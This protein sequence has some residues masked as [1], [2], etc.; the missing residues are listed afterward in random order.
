MVAAMPP[1]AWR[2][3]FR[4]REGAVYACLLLRRS[5]LAALLRRQG[6][7]LRLSRLHPHSPRLTQR[8]VRPLNNRERDEG[9]RSCV[10]FDEPS[11]QVVLQVWWRCVLLLRK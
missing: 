4:L 9:L 10:T 5:R 6:S 11:R 3:Q 8:Q 1:S 7:R 2:R